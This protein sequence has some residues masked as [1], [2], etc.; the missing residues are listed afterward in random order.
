MPESVKNNP[1]ALE[2]YN[3]AFK[4]NTESFRKALS[5]GL[6]PEYAVYFT[7]SGNV[8]S[9]IASMNGRELVHFLQLRSTS[10]GRRSLSRP[11]C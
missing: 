8:L 1:E 5:L 2:I 6:S 10:S 7:L 4:D 9:V 11:I 3:R